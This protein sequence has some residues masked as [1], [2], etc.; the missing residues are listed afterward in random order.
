MRNF[1]KKKGFYFIW[2]KD[3]EEE[4]KEEIK[5]E[6]KE[7]VKPEREEYYINILVGL[8]NRTLVDRAI[9]NIRGIDYTYIKEHDILIGA[10]GEGNVTPI[11]RDFYCEM[12]KIQLP[13]LNSKEREFLT[14]LLKAFNDVKGI[15]KSND[16]FDGFEFLRIV[17]NSPT[18]NM[19]LPRFRAGEYYSNLELDR[20]YSLEELDI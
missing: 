4:T 2:L 15:Q 8:V 3:K 7:I 14:N 12:C 16:I 13:L 20:L 19:D 5:E 1:G 6:P 17:S 9:Y 11:K 18:N 10:N